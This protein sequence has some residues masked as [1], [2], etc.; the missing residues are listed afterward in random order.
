MPVD[1]VDLLFGEYA[2]ALYIVAALLLTA[3]MA[4]VVLIR[5]PGY[6]GDH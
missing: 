5:D 1:P 6:E 2:L 4:V 3:S